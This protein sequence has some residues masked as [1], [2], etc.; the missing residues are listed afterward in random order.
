ARQR[1]ERADQPVV[2]LVPFFLDR[3]KPARSVDMDYSGYTGSHLVAKSQRT[4]HV[5]AFAVLLEV[6]RPVLMQD[7]GRERPEFF[8]KF[9]SRIDL[10]A[11][12]GLAR[13]GEYRTVAEC[14]GPELGAPLDPAQDFS[15]RQERCGS[16]R[17]I[18]LALRKLR[19]RKP[20]DVIQ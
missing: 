20:P 8:A 14:A 4:L 13:V 12:P 17:G 1:V 18:S 3:L 19:A 2:A 10:V 5:G 6:L 9:D 15:L 11:D 7:G 16:L